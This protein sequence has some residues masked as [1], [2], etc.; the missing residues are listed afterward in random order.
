MAKPPAI[1]VCPLC[2]QR[3]TLVRSHLV[4]HGAYMRA[5]GVAG[6]GKNPNPVVIGT[7]AQIQT[8]KEIRDYLLC[9]ACDQR[10]DTQGEN[11]ALRM[12]F[13]GQGSFRLL[14]RLSLFREV[15]RSKTAWAFSGVSASV[16][17][18][19]LAYFALSVLWRASI[20]TWK[21]PDGATRPPQITLGALQEPIRQHLVGAARFPPD[22]V[23][24]LTVC[25]DFLSQRIFDLPHLV[26][27][28][29]HKCFSFL[30]LGLS[31]RIFTRPRLPTIFES[32]C[33]VR[34][35]QK[36]VFMGDHAAQVEPGVRRLMGISAPIGRLAQKI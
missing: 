6:P 22:V 33:C 26:L 1:G 31:F 25:T 10:F 11:Y 17:T 20:H 23:V 34:S 2:L 35:R 15:E 32:I 13:D 36:L 21:L 7:R 28:N 27:E 12:C 4:P 29:Q 14:E 16:D 3:K 30:M 5:R 24:N 8:S 18:E 9:D 19:R